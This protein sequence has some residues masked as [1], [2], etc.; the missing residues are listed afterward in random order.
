MCLKILCV[1]G[2]VYEIIHF[3]NNK[4][5][6]LLK[7]KN[8]K[9][10]FVKFNILNYRSMKNIQLTIA[11]W[12]TIHFLFSCSSLIIDKMKLYMSP[13]S[14]RCT[15]VINKKFLLSS[16]LTFCA[17]KKKMLVIIIDVFIELGQSRI[18][19]EKKTTNI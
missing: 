12:N 15:L 11:V 19:A 3:S 2:T 6:I 14:F 13:T 10:E 8:T 16:E 18:S 4:N 5:V 17:V 7:K 1:M 9:I